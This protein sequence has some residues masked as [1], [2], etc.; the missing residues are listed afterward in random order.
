MMFMRRSSVVIAFVCT[1]TMSAWAWGQAPPVTAGRDGRLVYRADER[2]NR[3]PDFSNCGYAGADREIPHV[4]VRVTVAPAEGDD[5]ARI[6]RA[7]DYVASRALGDDGFR[8][9]VLLLPGTF[10]VAGQIRI[11]TSGVVLRGSGAIEGG[12]TIV[13]TG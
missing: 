9:T 5:G 12:T 8:G 1:A 6:Q 11:R 7:I 2:G 4:A 13:A 3:V 10:E